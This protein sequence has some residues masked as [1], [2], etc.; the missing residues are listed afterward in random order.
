MRSSHCTSFSTVRVSRTGPEHV[1]SDGRA[2]RAVLGAGL[3]SVLE[4]GAQR[5]GC[6]NDQESPMTVEGAKRLKAELHRLKTATAP[7]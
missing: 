1:G 5:Q 7:R 6:T 3:H 2:R 4:E